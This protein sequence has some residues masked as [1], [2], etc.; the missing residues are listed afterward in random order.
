M[1]VLQFHLKFEKMR[2]HCVHWAKTLHHLRV[3]SSYSPRLHSIHTRYALPQAMRTSSSV[4]ECENDK[5]ALLRSSVPDSKSALLQVRSAWNFKTND[6]SEP[7]VE[8]SKKAG[9]TN[10]HPQIKPTLTS[11]T[12]VSS[13]SDRCFYS[14]SNSA[15]LTKTPCISRR[16]TFD[17][18]PR[19][20]WLWKQVA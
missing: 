8:L 12:L 13:L 11:R 19:C 7:T 4:T 18:D 1:R 10:A 3:V 9:K 14:T 6:P 5:F 17:R 16:S 2:Y 15:L 20:T